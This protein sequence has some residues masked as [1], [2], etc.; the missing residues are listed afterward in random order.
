MPGNLVT[1]IEYYDNDTVKAVQDPNLNRTTYTYDKLN[2]LKTITNAENDT[3]TFEYDKEGNRTKVIDGKG[4]PTTFVY[5][6]ANRLISVRDAIYAT[7][8]AN[9]QTVYTYD[10]NGNLK[11]VKNARGY[12]T[13]FEYD[14]ADRLKS[15]KDPLGNITSY[16]YDV[17][18]F[19]YRVTDA[20]HN[21]MVLD[22]NE[23][24]RVSKV[25]F[26]DGKTVD[27][28]YDAIGN[29]TQMVDPTGTTDYY[30]I[31]GRLDTVSHSRN[32]I[33][34]KYNYD[35]SGNLTAVNILKGLDTIYSSQYH[36]NDRNL[37]D[38][39]TDTSGNTYTFNYDDLGNITQINYPNGTY[40]SFAYDK[41]NRIKNITNAVTGG[42]SFLTYDYLYDHNGRRTQ[43]TVNGTDITAYGYDDIGQLNQ[44]IDSRGT[45]TY[46]YDGTG[47]RIKIIGPN[48]TINYDYD[49]A[50]RLIQA[51]NTTYGY[52]NNGN[53]TSKTDANGT[54]TYTY[55][56]N[57]RL[58]GII[59][60]NG[61]VNYTYDGLGTLLSR[62]NTVSGAVYYLNNGLDTILESNAA[63]FSNPTKFTLGA[64]GLLGQIN[65]DATAQY[66]Y[67]DALGSL[68]AVGDQTGNITGSY[69]YDPWG[70]VIE[71][72]GSATNRNYTGKYG[73]TEEPEDGLIHMGARFYDPAAGIFLQTD[74]VKGNTGNPLSM[75][76][77]IYAL[78]DPA[79]L[80]DPDGQMPS[81]AW[82][83][84]K[85]K[86]WAND[87]QTLQS[88][89]RSK[90]FLGKDGKQLPVTGRY[91]DNT[92]E[93]HWN[94]YL[95][96]EAIGR[97]Y[98]PAG[99]TDNYYARNFSELSKKELRKYFADKGED[100]R[101]LQRFLRSKGYLADKYVT[102]YFGGITKSAL[103]DYMYSN[104]TVTQPSTSKP[105]NTQGTGKTTPPK[106]QTI[107]PQNPVYAH[108]VRNANNL[109]QQP[110]QTNT[111]PGIDNLI[112]DAV[113]V[114]W[115][116]SGSAG[117]G[118][119]TSS[120]II[121]SNKGID[122]YGSLE[123]NLGFQK[124]VD[125]SPQI[126][127]IWGDPKKLG[128]NY[129]S[130]NLAVVP[131]IGIDTAYNWSDTSK[132]FAIGPSVGAEFQ[133]SF[134]KGRTFP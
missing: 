3:V 130:A 6:K 13:V 116:H 89:L 52:D 9:H 106:T 96:R 133:A 25:T 78:N 44:V 126:L 11:T 79:N 69:R 22:Y 104:R 24:N 36:Y 29:L 95:F 10:L 14:G 62:E 110:W 51:G 86:E 18:G 66:F 84:K 1:T 127:I 30:Y 60:P 63:D 54:T 27:Y 102:G 101:H 56:F 41:A 7:D 87:A 33:E 61:S 2:R 131:G 132:V 94:Y 38:R 65:P 91:D 48:G 76:P 134:G 67:Y 35:S 40:T 26:P 115:A 58:T 68:G 46:N 112:P 43:M 90:G 47:N 49:E 53:R 108:H 72:T 23:M 81:S 50:N 100:V 119:S 5:D 39:L 31:K 121:I 107:V 57:N 124:G 12:I 103:L 70:T 15:I 45:T 99:M 55:D 75:V 120:D 42:S 80:I 77:Y 59:T 128:G 105:S 71:Q 93:A 28:K 114:R 8:P 85:R 20:N 34:I 123:G 4:N 74:P 92:L 64:G 16:E 111:P 118:Y 97:G 19:V 125:F 117:A 17:N 98:N 32:G 82:F 113:G 122:S 109:P 37:L 129:N 73:V 88:F 83:S 21:T